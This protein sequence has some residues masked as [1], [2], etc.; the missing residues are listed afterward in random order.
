M[1]ELSFFIFSQKHS[2]VALKSLHKERYFIHNAHN[3]YRIY[4]PCNSNMYATFFP[5]L[6]R[7]ER[8]EREYIIIITLIII[9]IR[10][11]TQRNAKNGANPIV[12]RSTNFYSVYPRR[13]EC[14]LVRSNVHT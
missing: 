4:I 7:W 13:I 9:I 3:T 8:K 5:V 6:R 2:T 10:G 1:S 14:A 11:M 12:P